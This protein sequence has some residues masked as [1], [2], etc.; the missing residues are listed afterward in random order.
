VSLVTALLGGILGFL[1]AYAAVRDGTPRSVR[2]VLT[3]FSGVAA[4]FAG[5]RRRA[6]ASSAPRR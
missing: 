1:I 2:T 5:S 3:T 4:N 6:L